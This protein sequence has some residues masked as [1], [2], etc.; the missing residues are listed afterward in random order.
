VADYSYVVRPADVRITARMESSGKPADVWTY[1]IETAASSD[2]GFERSWQGLAVVTV[3]PVV[4][5]PGGTWFGE[6]H[7]DVAGIDSAGQAADSA[8]PLTRWIP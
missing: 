5:A 3:W 4:V 1:P 7:L 8:L 2:A 6:L